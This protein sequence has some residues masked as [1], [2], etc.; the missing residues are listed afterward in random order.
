MCNI[1]F[2]G[3]VVLPTIGAQVPMKQMWKNILT[4]G[5][6]LVL[7]NSQSKTKR[8]LFNNMKQRKPD[9]SSHYVA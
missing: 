5:D 7:S 9:T 6:F 3:S 1:V 8:Y 4:Q 2:S